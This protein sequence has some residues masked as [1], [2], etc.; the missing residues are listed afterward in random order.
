MKQPNSV[1]AKKVKKEVKK[2]VSKATE[3]LITKEEL[4]TELFKQDKLNEKAMRFRMPMNFNSNTSPDNR[5]HSTVP[6][7]FLRKMATNYPIARACINRRIRQMTQLEW[8]ITTIDEEIDEKGFKPQIVAVKEAFKS[9]MG[10]KTRFREMLNIMVDDILTVDCLAFEYEKTFGGDL[11]NVVPVD[12]TT[13][14]LRVTETGGTPVPPTSAYAQYIA[15]TLIGEF[16]TDEML[17]ETYS[18][19]SYSPYGL[20]PLESLIIQVESAL[21]GAIYNLSFFKEGNIPEGFINLPEE[22]AGDLDQVKQWQSWFDNIMAG[23][24]RFQRRLKML[25]G[26]STYTPTKKAEDMAFER[27]EMWLLQQTCAVFDVQP[28]DIG[29]TYQVNKATGDTQQQ[30][31]RERGLIPLANFVKEILDTLI[32]EEM[33][34]EQLQLQWLD[35]NPTDRKE[36][37]DIAAKEIE[38][39]ALSVDEYRAEQGREA[40]GLDHYVKTGGTVQLVEDILNPKVEPVDAPNA[41]PEKEDEDEEELKELRRWRKA[42]Y[43]DF[44]KGR[45]LRTKFPSDKISEET[46]K[47]ISTSLKGINSKQQAKYLF[48]QYLNTEIK[49]SM[50]LLKAATEMR[51]VENATFTQ[52]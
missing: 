45:L 18:T 23:D 32:Q 8:D 47:S 19:R 31:G 7:F 39:G 49:A 22:I 17:Y 6:F 52:D 14:V 29:I 37:I 5:I 1:V 2:E 42:I 12:P 33:G 38:I 15:G 9:P 28:Q 35:L 13:I 34:F 41:K 26:E 51:R 20:A 25:P 48:D 44:D 40:I 30:I 16:T 3:G 11:L 50:K 21:Q 43:N 24:V 46:H 10:H 27:F 36:E 4:K